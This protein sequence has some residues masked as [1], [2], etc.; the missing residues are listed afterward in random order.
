[1]SSCATVDRNDVAAKVGEA[2]L[3]P[4]VAETLAATGPLA[5]T[6]D[7]LRAQITKWIRTAV[8]EEFNG[9]GNVEPPTKSGD[10]DRRYTT[11]IVAIA[12]PDALDLYGSGV[13]GSPVICLAAITTAT[14]EEANNVLTQLNNGTPFADA[15]RANSLDTVIAQ[16]GGIVR[17]GVNGDEEC[18]DPQTVNNPALITALQPASVGVPFTA[19]LGNFAAV[20]MLRPFDELLPD[21]QALIASSVLQQGQLDALVDDADIYV[22]PRY[23]RWDT[24]SGSVVAL[25]T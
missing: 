8:L 21:S 16:A 22:D 12:G 14:L 1:M 2:S 19:Q 3:T 15:A 24:A 11:A 10:L 20:L 23:G 17:G 9:Q 5:A 18:I 4:K 6:G 13:N 7:Q 25:T